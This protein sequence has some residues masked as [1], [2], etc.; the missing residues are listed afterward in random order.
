MEERVSESLFFRCKY[1]K[2]FSAV[3]ECWPSIFVGEYWFW[4]NTLFHYHARMGLLKFPSSLVRRKPVCFSPLFLFLLQI[5]WEDNFREKVSSP[6]LVH[7]ALPVQF[8]RKTSFFL[9]RHVCAVLSRG[10]GCGCYY[11]PETNEGNQCLLFLSYFLLLLLL[12]SHVEHTEYTK[13]W[14]NQN[15]DHQENLQIM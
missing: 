7:V 15:R 5:L 12:P 13:K 1:A 4:S 3:A 2:S 6:H 8:S 11:L 10:G 14:V 9:C